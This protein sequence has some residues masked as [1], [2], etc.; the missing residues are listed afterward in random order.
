MPATELLATLILWALGIA[1]A[2]TVAAWVINLIDGATVG[3]KRPA[4]PD[5]TK[6]PSS[7]R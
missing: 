1:A 5:Q 6:P 4:V 7:R 3:T 2:V